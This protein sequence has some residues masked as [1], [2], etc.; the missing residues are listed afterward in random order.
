MQNLLEKAK[1]AAYIYGPGRAV[2]RPRRSRC[3]A[4]AV[5]RIEVG[6]SHPF[7]GHA[8]N[9]RRL[10]IGR[11]KAAQVLVALVV[12]EDDDKVALSIPFRGPDGIKRPRGREEKHRRGY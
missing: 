2:P 3:R 7:G 11:A 8:I 10:D 4:N 6:E 1:T 5:G 9:I 12:G